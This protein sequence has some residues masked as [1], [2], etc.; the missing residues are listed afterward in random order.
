MNPARFSIL[1]AALGSPSRPT[2]LSGRTVLESLLTFAMSAALGLIAALLFAGCS[3]KRIEAAPERSSP[4]SSAVSAPVLPSIALS[5]IAADRLC[6]TKGAASIGS[7]VTQPTMRAIALDS[8]GDAASLS[9][10][11]RGD[12]ATS[13]SLASGESRRQLGLKLRAQDGCNLLYVMWRL[14]PAPSLSVSLK[15]NPGMRT[16]REC[17]ARGYM[18]LK[19]AR[20]PAPVRG[21]APASDPVRGPGPTASAL[22]A[23]SALAAVPALTPGSSHNLRAEI[24]GDELLAW[25]DDQLVWR[26]PL[27]PTA[28]SLSGP[29][30]LRSDNVRFDLVSFSAA[31][32]PSPASSK[33]S[34][35]A[36]D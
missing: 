26:G 2:P 5:P 1:H 7:P 35:D 32:A 9:F 10:T 30:G 31:P 36:S 19:P 24:A 11:F 6:V 18:P 22:A 14:D 21:P 16:H 15:H 4:P 29:A 27:P 23:G 13:R 34:T 20:A 17:G 28:R 3:A 25:I 12:T 33:C 8:S